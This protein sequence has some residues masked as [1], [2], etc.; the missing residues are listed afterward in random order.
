MANKSPREVGSGPCAVVHKASLE[1]VNLLRQVRGLQM[2]RPP[3]HSKCNSRAHDCQG[4][5]LRTENTLSCWIVMHM[6]ID[7]FA[8]A[9]VGIGVRGIEFIMPCARIRQ[10]RPTT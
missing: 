4:S 8:H 1:H 3:E 10:L 9:L 5:Q 2:R 7:L 6:R